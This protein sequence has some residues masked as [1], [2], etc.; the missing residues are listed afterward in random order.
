MPLIAVEIIE[1]SRE[2]FIWDLD[3]WAAFFDRVF[4]EQ[5]TVQIRYLAEHFFEFWIAG[6]CT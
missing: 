2:G 5:A 4:L 3:I 6:F 1:Y